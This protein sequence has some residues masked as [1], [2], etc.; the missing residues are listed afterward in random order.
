MRLAFLDASAARKS[1]PTVIRIM[2]KEL[3]WSRQKQQQE[4]DQAL[5]FLLTMGLSPSSYAQASKVRM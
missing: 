3:S 1:L 4:Y 5:R 2:A